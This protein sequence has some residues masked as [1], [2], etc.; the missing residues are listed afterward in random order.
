LAALPLLVVL[1]L[2]GIIIDVSFVDDITRGVN[3]AVTLRNFKALFDDPLIY[4]AL[5]NTVWFTI[6]TI[7]TAMGIGSSVAWLV[8]RTDLPGKRLVYMIMTIGLLVPTFFM[9]MGWVF[10]L[11]PRIGMLN[12][13]LMDWL[14]LDS[15]P[16][17]IANVVGMGWVEGLGLASMAFMMTGPIFK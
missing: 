15:A 5:L 8:E 7:V 16:L 6:V 12:R 2:L 1:V 3:S 11:H 14:S 13:W 4:S 17:S 9:A 10:F